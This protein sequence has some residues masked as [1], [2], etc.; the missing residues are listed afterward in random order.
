MTAP[1]GAYSEG[2]RAGQED[3]LRYYSAALDEIFRLRRALAL[4]GG[5]IKGHL[6]LKMFPRSR[7]EIT[8]AQVRRMQDAA[9]GNASVSYSG[10]D[11][12]VVEASMRDAGASNHLTRDQWEREVDES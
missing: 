1:L 10:I 4:E 9:C 6:N 11:Y 3:L 8:L 2:Y 5:T 12:H 7:R